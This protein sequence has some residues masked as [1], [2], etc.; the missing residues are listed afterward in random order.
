MNGIDIYED[1]AKRTKGDVYIG[2]VGPVRTGKSTFIRRF[3]ESVIIPG[4]T[5][6]HD[7]DVTRDSL[8]QSG[9][10]VT[11][12]TAE[13][14]FVPDK[15]VSV[16]LG[17]VQLRA[18]LIDCVGYMVPGAG[19]GGEDG[20]ERA[21]MTPWSD[22]P[23][24]F[25]EAAQ[26]GTDRVIRE[27]STIGVLVTTDGTFGELPRSAF[28]PAEEKIVSALEAAGKP[29]VIVLNSA[30][31]ET[32]EAEALAL[33]LED[34]YGA[35]VALIDA[36]RLDSEDAAG[37]L[38]SVLGEF[39]VRE[40]T[41]K[42]P[43]WVA[44]LEPE[45][46]VREAV[47]ASVRAVADKKI[48]LGDAAGAFTK[49]LTDAL[50]SSHASGAAVT[51]TYADMG[52]GK[53]TVTVWLPEELFYATLSEISGETVTSERELIR[54]VRSLAGA[55]REYDRVA[56]AME[57]VMETGYGIVMPERAE[58]RL[59]APEIVRQ[60]GGFGVR[61]HASAPTIHMIRAEIDTELSPIVGTEEQSEEMVRYLTEEMN[62]GDGEIWD[63]NMF[64]R[65]MYDLV[66]DGM[67]SKLEHMPPDARM[68]MGETLSRIVCEG[69]GGLICIIL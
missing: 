14:K 49:R 1:I 60:S 69:C 22:M 26:T 54:A 39:P 21:V 62:G 53:V 5:D 48:K 28:V 45:H 10:G 65:S 25:G 12:M 8:P 36:S 67:K 35:P 18:R 57:Q 3:A 51:D 4:I 13:P 9:D 15:A 38:A 32:K 34:K 33:S 47:L 42:Y 6:P 68:K 44:S 66:S 24:P 2:V 40:I 55:K 63:Y 7:A 16:R 29:Y 52:D 58:L 64:G 61:L 46:K 37:I 56:Q 27:H 11:V 19:D 41:V 20:E 43:G 23:M 59:D 30:A 50:G 31:P 17:D